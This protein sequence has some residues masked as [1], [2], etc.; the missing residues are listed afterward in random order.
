MSNLINSWWP[1]KYRPKNI[2]EYVGE[3]E[4]KDKIRGWIDNDE[5]NH[6]LLY[7][8]KPG[9]G[10]TTCAKMIAASLDADVLYINAS[11][12]NNI[13]MVREKIT[14]F[15]STIGFKKWK[16]V[17][18][19]E[20]DFLTANAQASMRAVLETFSKS[21]RFIF[22]ANYVERLIPAIRSRCTQFQI[23]TPPKLQILNRMKFILDS[24]NV[25]YADKD[26]AT[27]IKEFYPDQRSIIN[28]LQDNSFSGE[29]KISTQNII[30]N[31][32]VGKI[33]E[34]FK[35]GKDAKSMFTNIRQL[36]AD[37]KVKQFN[38][39]YRYLFDNLDEYAGDGKKGLII[40]SL[41]EGQY[42]DSLVIDKEIN[43][44]A[45]IVNILNIIKG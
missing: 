23:Q 42:K 10:K 3:S 33:V 40:L 11:M 34:I 32:Y 9:T 4:F 25:K 20:S 29:F 14:N 13:D 18:C 36:I 7:S 41:A 2:D 22:T 27:V 15:V 17:I 19:D 8:E 16:I 24:E 21:S 12:E 37:S 5:I 38:D 30:I 1:E 6:L 39:L 44:M 31:D 26:I 45:T 35:A 28:Y 43:A